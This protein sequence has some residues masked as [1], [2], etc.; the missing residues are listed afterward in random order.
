MCGIDN[1]LDLKGGKNHIRQKEKHDS[2]DII[3]VRDMIEDRSFYVAPLYV[4]IWLELTKFQQ[5]KFV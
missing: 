5:T 2:F 1:I 4:C 3:V